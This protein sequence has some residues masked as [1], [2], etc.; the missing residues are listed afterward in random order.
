[1]IPVTS[2]LA[3][4]SLLRLSL[5]EPPQRTYP[6]DAVGGCEQSRSGY[7]FTGFVGVR[8]RAHFCR[9][10]DSQESAPW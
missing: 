2:L 10:V 9:L 4:E 3:W 8:I 7:C 1:M 5:R 6:D